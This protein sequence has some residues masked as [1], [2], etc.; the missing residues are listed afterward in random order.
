[1][2]FELSEPGK[3][4]PHP[5]RA[6]Q[7]TRFRQKHKGT[8]P[9]ILAYSAGKALPQRAALWNRLAHVRARRA[10][11]FPVMPFCGSSSAPVPT[12]QL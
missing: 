1:M 4:S 11:N 6:V 3:T 12:K 7:D 5:A 9:P 2:D 10:P 8:D